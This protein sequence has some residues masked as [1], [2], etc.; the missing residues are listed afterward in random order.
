MWGARRDRNTTARWEA[1]ERSSKA[2]C[3]CPGETH[4]LIHD[5]NRECKPA[6][7]FRFFPDSDCAWSGRRGP[8]IYLGAPYLGAEV[9]RH[10]V[11]ALARPLDRGKRRIF[12]RQCFGFECWAKS[13]HPPLASSQ[14][15]PGVTGDPDS[16][17]LFAV[18]RIRKFTDTVWKIYN[19][20]I[21]GS[22]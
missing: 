12:Q 15:F 9:M 19:W 18:R 17:T 4:G 16:V 22:L 2:T 10:R 20:L 1:L 3:G 13:F 11:C 14:Q 6:G 21:L 5:P 7:P 8:C